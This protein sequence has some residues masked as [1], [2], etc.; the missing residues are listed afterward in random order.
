MKILEKKE[1]L[2]RFQRKLKNGVD[3]EEKKAL[4][5]SISSISKED[6]QKNDKQITKV[7]SSM[8][9]R[10]FKNHQQIVVQRKYLEEYCL[11]FNDGAFLRYLTSLL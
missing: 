7:E 5:E 10:T 8:I 2:K 6:L 9:F 4:L 3:L 11:A 1:I